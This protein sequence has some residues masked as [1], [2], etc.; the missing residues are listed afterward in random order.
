MINKGSNDDVNDQ[1][2]NSSSSSSST[3][4]TTCSTTSSSS[5]ESE[6][7]PKIVKKR[8]FSRSRSNSFDQKK[9]PKT[10]PKNNTYCSKQDLD[11]FALYLIILALIARILLGKV[12]A[13]I[14]IS[15]FLYIIP[16]AMNSSYKAMEKE[17]TSSK[18]EKEENHNGRTAWEETNSED[19]EFFDVKKGN[20]FFNYLSVSNLKLWFRVG[21]E[22]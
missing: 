16:K 7:D 18:E 14:F 1:Q 6:D 3:N 22:C 2:V 10:N 4:S 8:T 15:L 21:N 17:K 20:E 9:R 5:T 13:I 19:I 11:F 12:L